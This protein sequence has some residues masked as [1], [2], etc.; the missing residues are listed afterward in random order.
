MAVYAV[1]DIQGCYIAL[2]KVL[3]QVDF[4]PDKDV[5]WC[6]GDL[7]NRGADSLKVLRFLKSLGDAS[8]CVLGNHDL[9]LLELVGGGSAYR[10]DTLEQVLEA[11]DCDELIT[12]LRHRPLLHHDAALGWQ[13]ILQTISMGPST[14]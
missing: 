5:L 12:W 2:N 11:E 4:N 9:H 13:N 8:V 6:V 1:G 3:R 7:V 14:C 10:R